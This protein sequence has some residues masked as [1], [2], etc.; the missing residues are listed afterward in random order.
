MIYDVQLSVLHTLSYNVNH[1]ICIS[2]WFI[3]LDSVQWNFSFCRQFL[4]QCV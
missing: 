4:G 3:I 1:L 2:H